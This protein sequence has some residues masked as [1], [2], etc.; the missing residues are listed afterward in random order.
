MLP[1]RDLTNFM[2]VVAL[3]NVNQIALKVNISDLQPIWMHSP[4][5]ILVK[6]QTFL[7]EAFNLI[8]KILGNNGDL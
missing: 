2:Q 1:F 6:H 8:S 4:M 5:Q 3:F 7:C